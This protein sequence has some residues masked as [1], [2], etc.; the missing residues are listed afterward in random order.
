MMNLLVIKAE[1]KKS[2]H[3]F[4]HP[5]RICTQILVAV[6]KNKLQAILVRLLQILQFKFITWSVFLDEHRYLGVDVKEK[7]LW[8]D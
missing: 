8:L 3:L 5:C 1:A 7:Y 2:V 6:L 4:F